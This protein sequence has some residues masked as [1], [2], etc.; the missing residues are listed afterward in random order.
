MG[1]IAAPRGALYMLLV[2]PREQ[3][4][5]PYG[6]HLYIPYHIKLAATEAGGSERTVVIAIR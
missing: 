6:E 4:V 1:R 2:R 5:K 3:Q